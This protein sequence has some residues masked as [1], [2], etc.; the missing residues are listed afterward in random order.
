[1]GMRILVEL[2]WLQR[3]HLARTFGFLDRHLDTQCQ[4]PAPFVCPG[5]CGEQ[6]VSSMLRK[7]HIMF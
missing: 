7:G 4:L 6:W 1:M 5:L 2:F 3:R